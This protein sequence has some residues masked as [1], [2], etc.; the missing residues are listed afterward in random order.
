[1]V[2]VLKEIKNMDSNMQTMN[3]NTTNSLTVIFEELKEIR[4]SQQFLADQYEETK[5]QLEVAESKIKELSKDKKNLLG[6]TANLQSENRALQL[7]CNDL[8]QYS[9]RE[10]VEIKGVAY[11]SDQRA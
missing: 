11:N 8:E 6:L 3:L 2:D 7:I 10:C 4:K 1:M 5:Y 9:R